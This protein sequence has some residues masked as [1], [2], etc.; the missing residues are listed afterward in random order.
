[1]HAWKIRARAIVSCCLHMLSSTRDILHVPWKLQVGPPLGSKPRSKNACPRRKNTMKARVPSNQGARAAFC[2]LEDTAFTA[3]RWDG[4]YASEHRGKKIVDDSWWWCIIVPR[5]FMVSFKAML[6]LAVDGDWGH[7][8]ISSVCKRCQLS[9]IL[10]SY[11]HTTFQKKPSPSH[12]PRID[13]LL[14]ALCYFDAPFLVLRHAYTHIRFPLC[15]C[16]GHSPWKGGCGT[17]PP[18]SHV[19]KRRR[20]PTR[21]ALPND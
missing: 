19:T 7:K 16:D 6:S 8:S 2:R 15:A 20:K 21:R 9:Y 13:T 11:T 5:I 3:M 18:T 10:V 12:A 4:L 14:I 17:N 1:M